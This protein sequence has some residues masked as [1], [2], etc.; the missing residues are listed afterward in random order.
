MDARRVSGTAVLAV[1]LSGL[2]VAVTGAGC[3]T[4]PACDVPQ[5]CPTGQV[6]VCGSTCET[7]V[8]QGGTCS[9]DPCGPTPPGGACVAGTYCLATEPHQGICE[10]GPSLFDSC[11]PTND[12]CGSEL[13]C[14]DTKAC[15]VPAGFDAGGFDAGVGGGSGICVPAPGQDEPCDST[16]STKQPRDDD[17][18]SATGGLSCAPCAPGSFCDTPQ[19][20][21]PTY[22]RELCPKGTSSEC[23]CGDTCTTTKPPASIGEINGTSINLPAGVCTLCT[24]VGNACSPHTA[25]CDG[26]YCGSV[27]INGVATAGE[28]CRPLGN[29]CRR[30]EPCCD[31]GVC[32]PSGT[33]VCPTGW[34]ICNGICVPLDTVTNC[35]TCG[36]ACTLSPTAITGPTEP[37]VSCLGGVCHCPAA[38][39]DTCSIAGATVC[40]NLSNDPANCGKC[41]NMAGSGQS[42]VRGQI[43]NCAD[44]A[45]AACSGG[46]YDCCSPYV[47]NTVTF[48]CVLD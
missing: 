11:S 40:T 45:G 48:K 38:N 3:G 47:C 42:C 37:P 26:S 33:C 27:T 44:M 20:G 22:C 36:H 43:Q 17:K 1:A 10:P 35:D 7:P 32:D 16:L 14:L 18:A 2:Y 31:G 19:D 8:P 12:Q 41:G 4:P 15:G 39:P 21:L 6:F 46:A 9:T 24:T 30:G 29:A 34:G 25:C 5:T 13:F 23:P 28:C